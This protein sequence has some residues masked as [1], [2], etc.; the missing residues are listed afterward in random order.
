VDPATLRERLVLLYTGKSRSSGISNWDMLKRHLDGDSQVRGAMQG[1]IEATHKVRTALLAGDLD[2]VGPALADEW[3]A[4]KQLSPAVTDPLIDQLI[5]AGIGA[6]ALAGKVCGAGG[7]GCVVLWTGAGRR[8][9]VAGA[10]A[11]AGAEVLDFSCRTA[12]VEIT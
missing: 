4:R 1:V 8:E 10:I 3:E 7:G 5:E 9:D 6:G 2:G 11:S 12:G